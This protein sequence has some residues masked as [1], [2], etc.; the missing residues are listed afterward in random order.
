[1]TTFYVCMVQV[2]KKLL[3]ERQRLIGS[4]RRVEPARTAIARQG[5]LKVTH[6]TF[7]PP[8][9]L[10]HPSQLLS[11]L[12]FHPPNL[13]FSPH[14]PLLHHPYVHLPSPY[15]LTSNISYLGLTSPS[16]FFS[17]FPPPSFSSSSLI[18]FVVHLSHPHLVRIFI[19]FFYP[20][21]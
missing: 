7:P 17:S 21:S 18:L 2:R 10:S 9:L 11:Y 12:P 14:F 5:Y 3:D 6:P 13:P 8:T 16:F 20:S 1:M 19:R 4:D 15:F